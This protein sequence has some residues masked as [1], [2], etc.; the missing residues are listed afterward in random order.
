MAAI[1][2]RATVMAVYKVLICDDD[3]ATRQLV[4]AILGSEDYELV[5]ASDGFE[6][7]ARARAERPDAILLDL[8]MP[9]LDG[10][11]TCLQLKD[12][13]E[14]AGIP[15]LVLTAHSEF[16]ARVQAEQAHADGYLTKP[17]SPFTLVKAIEH[18][19]EMNAARR[20]LER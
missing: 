4:A 2:E 15:V 18:L 5:F 20:R 12:D 17:F 8:M 6:A 10:I 3:E 7:L 14:V 1:D 13:P 11:E 9:K 16:E 19:L